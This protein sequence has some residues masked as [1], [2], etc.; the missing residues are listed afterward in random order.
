MRLRRAG[1]PGCDDRRWGSSIGS[2]RILTDHPAVRARTATIAKCMLAP[3]VAFTQND[4]RAVQL[5]KAAI[6]AGIDC[7]LREAGLEEDAIERVV[8]AGAFG[9]YIGLE[10]AVRIGLLPALPLRAHRAGRQ[11]R[12]RRRAHGARLGS[13]ARS[14]PA[15]RPA[16]PLSRTRV[17]ARL[18]AGFHAENRL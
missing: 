1:R 6:R 13:T 18:S 16:L 11:C 4:V 10:S 9:A 2:G 14:R 5:A 3:G 8:I 7:L 12:R 15:S 17:A